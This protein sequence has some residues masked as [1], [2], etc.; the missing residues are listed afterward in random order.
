MDEQIRKKSHIYIQWDNPLE[1]KAS[2]FQYSRL[3]NSVDCMGS[4]RV[5]QQ[6]A[7]FT[8]KYIQWNFSHIEKGNSDMCY[9]MMKFEDITLSETKQSQNDKHS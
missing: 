1:K 8:F 5:G 9:S 7:T 3:E 4:Q 6:W 2:H